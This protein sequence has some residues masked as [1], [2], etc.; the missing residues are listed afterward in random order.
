L[1]PTK[2]QQQST[3]DEESEWLLGAEAS[4]GS[5]GTSGAALRQVM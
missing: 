5:I 1:W 4:A 3:T 2:S